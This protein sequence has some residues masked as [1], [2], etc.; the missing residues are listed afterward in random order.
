MLHFLQFSYQ[1]VCFSKKPENTWGKEAEADK[2]V[3]IW[4]QYNHFPADSQTCRTHR[5]QSSRTA[6]PPGTHG[7][8]AVPVNLPALHGQ[9]RLTGLWL[10]LQ[11]TSACKLLMCSLPSSLPLCTF[12]PFL[13]NRCILQDQ[14]S[15]KEN[16]NTMD[17]YSQGSFNTE[18]DGIILLCRVTSA[19]VSETTG[20]SRSGLPALKC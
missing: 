10:P 16:F 9:N 11:P 19:V 18:L 7:F 15:H 5:A 20:C 13:E 1:S 3:E 4:I 17:G 6:R 2:R 8:G 14:P 12:S